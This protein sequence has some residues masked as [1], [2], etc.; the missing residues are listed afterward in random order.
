MANPI[1]TVTSPV[2][3]G[4]RQAINIT[5]FAIRMGSSWIEGLTG[6]GGSAE[7]PVDDRP[8]RRS[9]PQPKP[10]DDV[11]VTRK[12]ETHIFRD[13]SVPKGKIDVNTV[14]GV[15][16]LRGEAKT[17]EMIKRLEREARSIPEVR[18][19]E[20]LLHLPKTP[21]PTR[22]DAPPSQRKTR[23][24]RTSAASRQ[25]SPR[26]VNAE[27]HATGPAAE[28]S[29]EELAAE[30]RGRQPAPFGSTGDTASGNGGDQS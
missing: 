11:A 30:H 24:T 22:A 18:K 4:A 26:R 14:E 17:P 1:K 19:V 21:A 15:V 27:K 25:V 2:A 20:N 3:F 10:L 16:W 23:R 13:A 5:Q 28:P 12:V 8:V 7:Q 29:P 9:S 6:R